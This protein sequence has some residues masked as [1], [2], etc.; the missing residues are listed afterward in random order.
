MAK[1]C[2]KTKRKMWGGN[3]Q[4][5]T[6]VNV[7]GGGANLLQSLNQLGASAQAQAIGG[8]I[9]NQVLGTVRLGGG[10]RRRR[11]HKRRRSCKCKSLR[12]PNFLRF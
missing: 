10:R 8:Q 7:Q 2:R 4:T 5:G 9:Q 1:R 11:T 6:C 3:C 12:L